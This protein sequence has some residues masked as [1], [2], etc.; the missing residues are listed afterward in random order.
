MIYALR[1][2]YWLHE[3]YAMQSVVSPYFMMVSCHENAFIFLA[4]CEVNPPAG[5]VSSQ[6]ANAAAYLVLVS[7]MIHFH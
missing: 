6:N 1:W 4:I 2:A 7:H 5:R 3:P